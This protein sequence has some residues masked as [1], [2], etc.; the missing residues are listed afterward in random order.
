MCIAHL[1][2]SATED[3]T[4]HN[5]SLV[6]SRLTRTLLCDCCGLW[7]VDLVPRPVWAHI[8]AIATLQNCGKHRHGSAGPPRA[9]KNLRQH[10]ILARTENLRSEFS[11]GEGPRLL[12]GKRNA[13]VAHGR[14]SRGVESLGGARACTVTDCDGGSATAGPFPHARR[15]RERTGRP[16]PARGCREPG[17]AQCGPELE[18]SPPGWR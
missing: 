6:D 4:V 16:L 7:R 9:I 13:R 10:R 8:D 2:G 17:T 14:Y 15:V 18:P 3:Q 12:G 1:T 11:R 5:S